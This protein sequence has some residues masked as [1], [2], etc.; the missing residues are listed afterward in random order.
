ME[1]ISVG[2]KE[3]NSGRCTGSHANEDFALFSQESDELVFF[4]MSSQQKIRCRFERV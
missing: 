3:T 2:G 4:S 1:R